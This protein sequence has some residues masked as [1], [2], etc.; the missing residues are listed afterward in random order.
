LLLKYKGFANNKDLTNKR[1]RFCPK[2]YVYQ[3]KYK[4]FAKR[5]KIFQENIKTFMKGKSLTKKI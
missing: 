3:G 2:L 4:G 1:W 5:L